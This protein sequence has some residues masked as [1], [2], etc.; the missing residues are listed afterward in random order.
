MGRDRPAAHHARPQFGR[1]Y[2]RRQLAG[3]LAL[4]L[5]GLP[6]FLIHW[7]VVQREALK[8]PEERAT[9]LRAVY[10]YGISLGTLVPIVQNTLAIV[11][12]VIMDVTRLSGSTFLGTDQSYGDNL[13]AIAFNA[14]A[15]FYFWTSLKADWRVN[16]QDNPLPETRRLYRYL[17]VLYGL[18]LTVYGVQQVLRY[19]LYPPH[20][21]RA[22]NV[23]FILADG[24]ALLFVGLPLWVYTWQTVQNAQG[25]PGESD[26]LLRLII[27]Y[28]LALIAVARCSAPPSWR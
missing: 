20:R 26:S 17:W 25:E 5:V 12:R 22:G 15:A 8:N 16:A 1:R 2:P 11:H 23:N 13:V 9:T 14:G 4:I 28:L 3:S 19:I 24:I 21:A 6:V 7:G 27:L 18:G 10:L